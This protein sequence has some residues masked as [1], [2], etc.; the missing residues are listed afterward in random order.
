MK[1]IIS[2][3]CGMSFVL[4][5]CAVSIS[6][7]DKNIK[8]IS[9][10]WLNGKA[11][12]LVKPAYPAAAL[13]VRASGVVIMVDEEGNIVSAKAV[14]GHPLLRMAA[15]K[16]ALQSKITP[17][18]LQGKP[19]TI[20][21]I[22][23]FNF[24]L[25]DGLK[26]NDVQNKD[27]AASKSDENVLNGKAIKLPSPVY[28]PAAKSVNASGEVAVQVTVDEKGNV[29]SAEAVSG[30]PLLRMAAETAALKAKFAP[31]VSDGKPMP[32]SGIIIYNFPA[33]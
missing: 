30:H 27:S 7:Q 8:T 33:K 16:A 18:L 28:P 17:T 11:V 20:T 24:T 4:I 10:G 15:E 19:V 9:S 26:T 1:K 13:A 12:N 2:I 21:G 23:V 5:F 3:F 22:L 14:S 31:A 32:V 29:I 25:E 6:A